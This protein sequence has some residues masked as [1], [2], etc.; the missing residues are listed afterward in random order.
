MK[1]DLD[2]ILRRANRR[3]AS[4][5]EAVEM[6]RTDLIAILADHAR[7]TEQVRVAR[8]VA[9]KLSAAINWLDEPFIDAKTTEAELRSRIGFM[10]ADAKAPRETLTRIEKNDD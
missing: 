4:T 5:N 2:T 10:I 1:D 6:D 7:L 8:E 3:A 9:G